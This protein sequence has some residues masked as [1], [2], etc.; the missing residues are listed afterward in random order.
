MNLLSVPVLVA[1]AVLASPALWQA[2]TGTMPFDVAVQRYLVV[3][4]VT[5]LALSF[6]AAL[7][8]PDP[9]S[10]V[11]HDVPQVDEPAE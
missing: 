5:W 1:A 2:V 6:V 9:G 10:G 8:L 3:V 7:V 11:G 4:V